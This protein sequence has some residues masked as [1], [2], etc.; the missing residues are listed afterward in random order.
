MNKW[1]AML[2]AAMLLVCAAA[3]AMA[4]QTAYTLEGFVTELV[5]GGFIMEDR[6]LGEVVL[7]TDDTTVWDGILTD[8]PIEVG[9][10]V[11]VQYDGKL[12]RSIPPQAHADKVG[13]YALSG[14]AG[15]LLENGVLL[16]GDEIFGDVIVHLDAVSQPVFAGVPMT[17][18]YNG[19][20]ALSLPGQV[21]ASAVLV[22]VL[23]GTVGELDGQGFTLTTG[24]D[25]Q[26]RVEVDDGTLIAEEV[27]PVDEMI[28][29]DAALVADGELAV[30]EV[31][32]DAN[33]DMNE[34]ADEDG[35]V[36]A[37]KPTDADTTDTSVPDASGLADSD[38]TIELNGEPTVTPVASLALD[39]LIEGDRVRVY[40]SGEYLN[41]EED[42][43][44]ALEVLILLAGE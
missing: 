40:Y 9:Q 7:N 35:A 29:D 43:V 26:Y 4:E 11:F 38:W 32:D 36:N 21:S 17:V 19:V 1:I 34:A 28:A 24:A 31:G 3:P 16:T 15:E 2:L 6:E 18:Y 41:D 44:L 39:E 37:E 30:D 33:A 12:T 23:E 42:A 27:E 13:C 8:E 20:M 14:V 5:E 22:P 25:A 10:Y